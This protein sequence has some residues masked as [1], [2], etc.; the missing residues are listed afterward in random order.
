MTT[1]FTIWIHNPPQYDSL[2]EFVTKIKSRKE[3]NVLRR[4]GN[5]RSFDKI[6]KFINFFFCSVVIVELVLERVL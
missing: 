5:K 3:E 1:T 6:E 2:L 4:W